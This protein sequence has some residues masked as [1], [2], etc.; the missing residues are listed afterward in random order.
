MRELA[1][2]GSF[3]DRIRNLAVKL[4]NNLDQK[5]F[6]GEACACLAFVRDRIRY[7]RDI[8]DV[9]TVHFPTTLLD[10]GAGDCDDKSILLAA[11]L[12]SIGHRVRFIAIAFE[13][14]EYCH[15]WVQDYIDGLGWL[16]LEP[17]EPIG[18]GE[19]IPG[20]GA[21]DYLTCELG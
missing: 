8:R 12:N 11:L 3:Q 7:V 9:E 5:D 1:M 17:T 10:A 16:D 2:A 4:T 19:R 15:V 6:R 20:D 13:P 14:D 21:V 18:C